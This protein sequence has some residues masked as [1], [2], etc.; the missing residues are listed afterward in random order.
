ME[1]TAPG[2]VLWG[3]EVEVGRLRSLGSYQLTWDSIFSSA[4]QAQRCATGHLS[5][6]IWAGSLFPWSWCSSQDEGMG[7]QEE[8]KM[9]EGTCWTSWAR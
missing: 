2:L 1:G 9:Y 3:P 4:K 7:L 6:F 8:D 5:L